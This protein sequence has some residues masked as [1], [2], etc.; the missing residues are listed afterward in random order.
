MTAHS[1]PAPSPGFCPDSKRN[2]RYSKADVGNRTPDLL[3]TSEP[4]CHLSYV[5]L[6]TNGGQNNP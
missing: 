6:K 2:R 4:L 5:G 1:G 3:I